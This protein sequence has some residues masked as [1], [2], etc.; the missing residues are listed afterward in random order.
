MDQADAIVLPYH[1][2]SLSGSL[3]IA[4]T[5]GLPTVVTAVGGLVEEM[6]GYDGAVVVPPAHPVSL[7]D[8]LLKLPA[9]RGERYR[10]RVPGD[11]LW[12]IYR[13]LISE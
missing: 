12:T 4:M 7:R 11:R 13:A 10:I 1:R 8:T 2:A 3:F 5:A 6:E 9:R